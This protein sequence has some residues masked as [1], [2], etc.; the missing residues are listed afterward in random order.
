MYIKEDFENFV[1]L[2]Q[3]CNQRK[4]TEKLTDK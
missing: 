2:D 1:C 3:V 4:I